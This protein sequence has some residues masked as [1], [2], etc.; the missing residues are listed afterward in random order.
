MP[1]YEIKS[2]SKVEPPKGYQPRTCDVFIST[3]KRVRHC[4]S[5]NSKIPHGVKHLRIAGHLSSGYVSDI[6]ICSH[7]LSKFAKELI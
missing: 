2:F 1:L 6:N 5:C 4:R 7:C 3:G